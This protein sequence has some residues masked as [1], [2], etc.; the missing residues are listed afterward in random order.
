MEAYSNRQPRRDDFLCAADASE[1]P[2]SLQ[3]FDGCFAVPHEYQQ[4]VDCEA[5][6]F[7]ITQQTSMEHKWLVFCNKNCNDSNW[8]NDLRRN[9]LSWRYQ[10]IVCTSRGKASYRTN[11]IGADV[12]RR[13]TL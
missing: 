13:I 11:R 1:R 12:T 9:D 5:A 6:V 2:A 10:L 8:G 4:S 7:G 3:Q